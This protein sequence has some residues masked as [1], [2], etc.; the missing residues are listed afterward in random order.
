MIRRH[1]VPAVV[2]GVLAVALALPPLP[3]AEAADAQFVLTALDTLQKNYVDPLP[4]PPLLNAA[5]GALRQKFAASPFGGPI[6]SEA[7]D[8]EAGALF[9]QRFAEILSQVNDRY[10]ATDLAYAA[11]SGML[12]S[13]NDSHT[14]FIPPAAYQEEKRRESG[15][16]AFTGIGIVLLSRDG[17]FYVNEVYPGT[18][19]ESA[20]VQPFD[21]VLAVDGAS[22]EGLTEGDVSAMIR[23]PAETHVV[24]MVERAG[25]AQP[26]QIPIVRAPIRPPGVASR[27]LEGGIGY[28]RLYEFVPGVGH[29]FR[30]AIF[31][32]RR[33][34]MRALVLDLRGNPGGLVDEL[35]DVSAAVLPPSAPFLQMKTRG[36]RQVVLETSSPPIL[37]EP[38]PLVVLVDEETGSAAEL[39]AAALQEQSRAVITGARTAGA[40]EIG[41]TMD[42]PEGAG[43]SITVARVLS[44]KGAR[45]EHQGVTPDVSESL[46]TEAMNLG[47]D[48]QLDKALEVLKAKMNT[49]SRMP[50]RAALLAAA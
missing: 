46:T 19:A 47:H 28:V 21:R 37:P 38:I 36:G 11:V 41:I 18:P 15:L 12:E 3:R 33:D 13:L 39:L 43:M 7:G 44:G 30:D 40:V 32:L 1:V 23:G 5:L 27:M 45:L 48:S 22:T 8:R 9:T 31:S 17:Q 42:L 24:L 25:E 34:G 26:R 14:G 20:G 29:S 2:I 4:T 6:P 49:A 35:R 10:S 16:A 50:S